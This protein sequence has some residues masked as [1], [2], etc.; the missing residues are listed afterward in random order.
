MRQQPPHRL[1]LV[2]ADAGL[3]IQMRICLADM[4][5]QVV[6]AGSVDAFWRCMRS[7]S[8][9]LVLL[10]LSLP[11]GDGLDLLDRLNFMPVHTP[12]FVISARD[13]TV[14]RLTAL[15]RMASDFITK[16]FDIRELQLRIRNFLLLYDQTSNHRR[17]PIAHRLGGW[18]IVPETR[19]LTHDNGATASLT[20]GEAE[21]LRALLC[22]NGAVLSRN[23]LLDTLNRSLGR[24]S[25]ESLTVLISRLRGKL[26]AGE[27]EE[28][29]IVTVHGVGYRLQLS[30]PGR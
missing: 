28:D 1:L 8:V 20:A 30:L 11:D 27:Q 2:E 22:S 17:P 26:A 29:R 7:H 15:E 12:V 10:D 9:D 18:T 23:T 13:D 5:Y 24:A 25:P 3:R 21:L 19:T 6:E 4:G 14:S 16:P